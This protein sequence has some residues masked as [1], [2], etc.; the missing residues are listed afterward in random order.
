MPEDL[1][2]VVLNQKNVLINRLDLACE[3]EP[4]MI[5]FN[6]DLSRLTGTRQAKQAKSNYE[7]LIYI[8]NIFA[9]IEAVKHFIASSDEAAELAYAAIKEMGSHNIKSA[10]FAV[11]KFKEA[12]C[13]YLLTETFRTT[14]GNTRR[15]DKTLGK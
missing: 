5:D 4:D 10:D 6:R 13:K 3:G 15:R 8:R 2:N 11:K 9:N 14:E 7:S 12:I 1:K